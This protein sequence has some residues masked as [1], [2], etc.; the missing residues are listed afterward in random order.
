MDENFQKAKKVVW[1]AYAAYFVVSLIMAI[2]M[3]GQVKEF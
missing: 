2:G 3:M 1:R